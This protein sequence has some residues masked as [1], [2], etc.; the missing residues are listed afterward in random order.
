MKQWSCGLKS[1]SAS[2][3][4]RK[5]NYIRESNACENIL[6]M[7]WGGCLAS[8]ASM[9]RIDSS[10]MSRLSS[11]LAGG[12]RVLNSSDALGTIVTCPLNLAQVQTMKFKRTTD[13][14]AKEGGEGIQVSRSD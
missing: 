4:N 11:I 10:G 9:C 1:V 14:S 8:R 12:S 13:G 7:I 5:T 6:W 2:T 3:T